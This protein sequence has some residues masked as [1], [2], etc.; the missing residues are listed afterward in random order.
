MEPCNANTTRGTTTAHRAI[1]KIRPLLYTV[2]S[3][4]HFIFFYICQCHRPTPQIAS[5]TS[6]NLA[7]SMATPNIRCC[8]THFNRPIPK[9]LGA[10]CRAMDP[11]RTK[12]FN[13]ST[14]VTQPQFTSTNDFWAHSS[15]VARRCQK[16]A[17]PPM[18]SPKT[19]ICLRRSSTIAFLRF[20]RAC[21]PI[22]QAHP[23]S[24]RFPRPVCRHHRAPNAHHTHRFWASTAID[25][26]RVIHSLSTGKPRS[27]HRFTK[28]IHRRAPF[29]HKLSR[30]YPQPPRL[31]PINSINSI[32]SINMRYKP[33]LRSHTTIAIHNNTMH[34]TNTHA[35]AAC[36][37]RRV[38]PIRRKRNIHLPLKRSLPN[39]GD[40]PKT[41]S[42]GTS[43]SEIG[44]SWPEI[45]PQNT[46]KSTSSPINTAPISPTATRSL[47]S[48]SN[49]DHRHKPFPHK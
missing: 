27:A 9:S 20:H 47:S 4:K 26:V 30:S 5:A 1:G 36:A 43:N 44:I 13:I 19:R 42:F 15:Y 23:H 41:S 35:A 31:T 3:K 29:I 6:T 49:R 21:V 38:K 28:V 12:S 2:L 16:V 40:V 39:S 18:E 37:N 46:A 24:C 10:F 17:L 25:A 14:I 33:C 32:H 48:K 22:P 34:T 7:F 8:N 11:H 45:T